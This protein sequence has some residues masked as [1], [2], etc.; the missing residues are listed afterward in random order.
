M[1]DSG[2]L[3]PTRPTVIQ[4]QD[5]NLYQISHVLQPTELEGSGQFTPYYPPVN[6]ERYRTEHV[7]FGAAILI[8][9]LLSVALILNSVRPP[10]PVILPQPVEKP[11][12]IAFC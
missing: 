2:K 6:P 10:A 1:S 8:G 12:C 5:G 9:G 11:S 3:V 4:A 7:I